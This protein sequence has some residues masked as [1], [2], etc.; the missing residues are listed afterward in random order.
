MSNGLNPDQ[1]QHSLGPDLGPNYLQSLSV[2]DKIW[3]LKIPAY[4]KVSLEHIGSSPEGY[5]LHI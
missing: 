2:Y 1:N 3:Q 4:I 5:F